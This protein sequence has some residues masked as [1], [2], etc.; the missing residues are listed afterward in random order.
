[1]ADILKKNMDFRLRRTVLGCGIQ[2][3]SCLALAVRGS[4]RD[5]WII[6][7]GLRGDLDENSAFLSKLRK[8][9]WRRPLWVPFVEPGQGQSV[10][11]RQI[12]LMDGRDQGG[13]SPDRNSALRTQVMNNFSFPKEKTVMKGL[14]LSN[15]AGE[16]HLIGAV[17]RDAAVTEEYRG[18]KQDVGIINPH[19][20]SN[21]AALANTYLALNG[22]DNCPADKDRMLLMLGRE[23]AVAVLMRG[24]RLIDSVQTPVL[25]NQEIDSLIRMLLQHF[26]ESASSG[27]PKE[28]L[29]VETESLEL[30]ARGQFDIWRAFENAAI[31]YPDQ[32][33][34]EIINSNKDLATIAFGMAL[35]GG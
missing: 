10:V 20:G 27:R 18:W 8:R 24:W 11:V 12:E 21:A 31:S 35:Q 3:G 15:G 4:K 25:A 19:I 26:E 2:N 32:N 22:D 29:L 13:S 30:P 14:D 23:K 9:V 7:W 17:A 28:T 6:E 1:M 5:G 33:I 34:R 16:R